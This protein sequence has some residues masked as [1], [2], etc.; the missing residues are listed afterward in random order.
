M[1]DL[2]TTVS[3]QSF[4]VIVLGAGAAGLMCA[5]AAG[6]R[7]RRVLVLDHANKAGKKILMSGGGRCN[8]TNLYLE[9]EHYLS[10]NPHFCKSA[11]SRFT[12]WDFIDLVARHRIPYHEKT[13]GRLYCDRSSRDILDMLL[14]ECRQ[15][16]VTLRLK[17]AVTD[18]EPGLEGGFAL[19]GEKG[20]WRCR[21]LVIATGGLS[22]PKM[23]ATPF[24]YRLA[25]RFGHTIIPPRA[26]LVP[27]VWQGSDKNRFGD[28]AG[29]GLSVLVSVERRAFEEEMLFT[30]R[31]LSGP[32]ILQISSYWTPGEAVVIDL[33]PG[34]AVSE[35]ISNA[36]RRHPQ[37]QLKTALARYLPK[38]LVP[39]LLEPHWLDRP[40]AHVGDAGIERISE[41]I[42]RWRVMPGGTEG[43]RTAEVTLGGVHCDELSSK[44][45]ASRIVPDLYFIGEV[46][47]VTGQLGGYNFQWAWSSGWCAG[48]FV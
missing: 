29:I 43:Y 31:G 1:S 24:G 42:H 39:R 19:A 41:C 27:F 35:I 17:T 36:R 5:I 34:R 13:R 8:F 38:R 10:R 4:D 44:T 47:D 11:L 25:E 21:S 6:R 48:Q 2:P 12:Q 20:E 14:A 30:H 16:G 9:A 46:V 45:L 3:V 22:I 33:S 40:L 32:A 23:G 7:G 28:L 18:I 26:G 15:A 37:Q